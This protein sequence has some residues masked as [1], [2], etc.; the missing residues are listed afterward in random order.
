MSRGPTRSVLFGDQIKRILGSALTG[1]LKTHLPDD[2]LRNVVVTDVEISSDK[3]IAKVFYSPLGDTLSQEE[4]RNLL[5][6]NKGW[7]RTTLAKEL[8]C[9]RTPD[10]SFQIDTALEYG[11]NIDRLFDEIK[12]DSG[13]E[14][15][16]E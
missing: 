1:M 14:F 4:A 10:L 11:R 12:K 16:G 9:R 7:L 2:R 5:S 8:R 6:D 3:S 13:G 15:S